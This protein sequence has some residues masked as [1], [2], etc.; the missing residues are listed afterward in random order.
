MG[1]SIFSGRRFKYFNGPDIYII[2]GEGTNTLPTSIDGINWVGIGESIFSNKCLKVNYNGLRWVAAGEGTNT[3]A[4]STDGKNWTGNT[5]SMFSSI[6]HSAVSNNPFG[7]LNLPSQ[8]FIDEDFG[9]R[10][11]Y[12]LEF[13]SDSTYTNE[14]I[15]AINITSEYI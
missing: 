8:L 7:G 2:C 13:V 5:N 11:T 10:K 9:I 4:Y 15:A 12:K 3:L 14:S 6:A 1:T